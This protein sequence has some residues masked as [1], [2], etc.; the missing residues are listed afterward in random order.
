MFDPR[1][2][3]LLQEIARTGSLSAA[4]LELGFSQPAVSYQL[5]SLEREVGTVLVVRNG[6][7]TRLTPA[8]E[9]LAVHANTILSSIQTAEQN[10]ADIVG[11]QAGLVRIAAFPSG[12]ATIV[13]AAMAAM[14]R[15]RSAVEIQLHQAEP[16]LALEMV[17]RGEAD[18]AVSYR[19]DVPSP[20]RRPGAREAPLQRM[21]LLED[22]MQ[23][24]LPAGHR[25]AERESIATG[26]LAD[27]TW[28][29]SSPCFEGI[30]QRAA[31]SAGFTPTV[32]MVADDYVAMQAL[33][34]HGLGVAVL[35]RLSLV[36]HHDERVV[37]RPVR[38]WPPRLVEVELWPDRMRVDAVATMLGALR[39]ACAPHKAAGHAAVPA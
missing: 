21:P 12:C 16:P 33:V 2:L 4:A 31:L 14:R 5:R 19:Y 29:I 25:L 24:V 9:A 13:P 17:R 26:D 3:R 8:G 20:N 38:G 36:A 22:P 30:L 34:A 15:I 11:T 27:A 6:R 35:P 1:H 7:T 23:V 28:I 18:V 39:E 32:S 10:L 37:S